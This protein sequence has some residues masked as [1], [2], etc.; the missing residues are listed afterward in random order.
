LR[1]NLMLFLVHTYDRHGALNVRLENRD[2]HVNWLKAAGKAVKAAGPWMNEAGDMA[3]SLLI[4]E[5][6]S[7]ATLNAWLETD[8]YAIA[9]LFHCVETAP[10]KWVIN[11]PGLTTS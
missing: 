8:P 10:Y 1:E 7:Q 11:A 4:V 5:S 6:D 3:G 2:A 9:G